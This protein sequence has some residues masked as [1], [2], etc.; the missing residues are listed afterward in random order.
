MA[1]KKKHNEMSGSIYV[2]RGKPSVLSTEGD[3]IDNIEISGCAGWQK[4][5]QSFLDHPNYLTAF[6]LVILLSLC[7]FAFANKVMME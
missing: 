2:K 3:E 7:Q 4:S 1:V 6:N 5:L